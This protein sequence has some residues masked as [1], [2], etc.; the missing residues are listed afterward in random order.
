[1]AGM[2]CFVFLFSHLFKQLFVIAGG[3][4]GLPGWPLWG[5]QP[6]RH[7]RQ[8]CH[9]HAKGHP[10]GQKNPRRARLRWKH[11][12]GWRVGA[13]RAPMSNMK[14]SLVWWKIVGNVKKLWFYQGQCLHSAYP[15]AHPHL[16][17]G[18]VQVSGYTRVKDQCES[19]CAGLLTLVGSKFIFAVFC[20]SA[21]S[22]IPEERQ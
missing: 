9:H 5:H 8:A 10:A 3:F 20:V 1:M 11:L 13:Q 15:R 6:V 19:C 7:P 2:F 4:W 22:E 16:C 21:S 12:R 17:S 18:A 14:T